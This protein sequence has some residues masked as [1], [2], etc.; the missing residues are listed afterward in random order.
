MKNQ[1]KAIANYAKQFIKKKSKL[2]IRLEDFE[3]ST[4]AMVTNCKLSEKKH[5][6]NKCW[7]L[8]AECHNC[9]KTDHIAKFCKKKII[10]SSRPNTSC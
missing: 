8:Q 7:H 2:T 1:D 3:D 5:K 6:P 9:Y 10:F 4:T